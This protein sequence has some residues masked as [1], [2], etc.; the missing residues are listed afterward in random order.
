[1]SARN[2]TLY[3]RRDA[4]DGL[5]TEAVTGVWVYGRYLKQ[6]L[7]YEQSQSQDRKASS[8]SF[9]SD[10]ALNLVKILGDHPERDAQSCVS[11]DVL[12]GMFLLADV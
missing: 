1:M 2:K 5:N 9:Q 7:W 12:E 10:H 6:E 4:Y 11:Q 3:T 8:S